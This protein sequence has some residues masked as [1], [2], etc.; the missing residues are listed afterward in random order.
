[1]YASVRQPRAQK[2]WDSSKRAGDIY[3][4]RA[5]ED[6]NRFAEVEALEK[7]IWNRPVNADL[8]DAEELLVKQGV[9]H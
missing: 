4:G 2:V 8:K 9:F 7:Y 3:E 6:P 1:M 5:G